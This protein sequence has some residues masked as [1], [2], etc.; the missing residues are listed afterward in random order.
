ME[1]GQSGHTNVKVL[2]K[3]GRGGLKTSK[4]HLPAPYWD[5]NE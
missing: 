5:S 3:G 4:N 1:Y 2:E